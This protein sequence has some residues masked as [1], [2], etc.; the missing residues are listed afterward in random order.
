MSSCWSAEPTTHQSTTDR[1]G[2]A[3]H[4]KG[5]GTQVGMLAYLDQ[6]YWTS[7]MVLSPKDGVYLIHCFRDPIRNTSTTMSPRPTLEASASSI[8]TCSKCD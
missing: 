1:R 3:L 8:S 7:D 6:C 5:L 2:D 4:R